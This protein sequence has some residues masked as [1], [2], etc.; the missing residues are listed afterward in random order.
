MHLY[1]TT[2][3]FHLFHTKSAVTGGGAVGVGGGGGKA[4]QSKF[5]NVV[6]TSDI[7]VVKTPL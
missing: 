3:L 5:C 7:A 4:D 2:V 1:V 6:L